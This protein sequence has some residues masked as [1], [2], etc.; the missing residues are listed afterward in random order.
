[1]GKNAAIKV[2]PGQFPRGERMKAARTIAPAPAIEETQ[3]SL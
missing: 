1:M 3:V 2:V